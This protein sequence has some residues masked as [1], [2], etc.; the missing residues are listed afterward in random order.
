MSGPLLNLNLT[1][2]T[3]LDRAVSFVESLG[4]KVFRDD[5]SPLKPVTRIGLSGTQVTDAGLKE[6]APLTNVSWLNLDHTQVTDIGLEQLAPLRNRYHLNL[7]CTQVT[8]AG[9]EELQKT[10]PKCNIL[11]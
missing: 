4:G 5:N 2:T 10:L 3:T 9:I 11:K 1:P 7:P 6:L 8:D